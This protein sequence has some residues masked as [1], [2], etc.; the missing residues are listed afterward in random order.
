[1]KNRI[2]FTLVLTV[3]A[4]QLFACSCMYQ[5]MGINKIM[6]SEVL[7]SGKIIDKSI[8]RFEEGKEVVIAKDD[9]S[10]YGMFKYTLQIQERIKGIGKENTIHFYSSTSSS[11]C[12]VNYAEGAELYVFLYSSNSGWYTGACSG[13][14]SKENL[15]DEVKSI[16]QKF[17]AANGKQKWFNEYKK[18]EA[19]GKVRKGKVRGKWKFYFSDGTLSA[20]G[21]YKRGKKKGEWKVYQEPA[22]L[23]EYD[24]AV[25]P[26]KEKT[27]PVLESIEYYKKGEKLKT[28]TVGKR[29]TE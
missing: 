4:F 18:L 25:D 7:V 22:N 3:F 28:E 20:Q 6:Q 1:M 14:I 10:R 13:N 16:I 19:I 5:P 27:E 9:D 11:I 24:E 21:K 26:N 12:G 17:K 23:P 2:L 15:S 29:E 8:V